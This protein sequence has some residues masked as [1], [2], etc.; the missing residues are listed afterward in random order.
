MTAQTPIHPVAWP[1]PSVPDLTDSVP[2]AAYH[3]DRLYDLLDAD[4][5]DRHALRRALD[6]YTHHLDRHICTAAADL[7]MGIC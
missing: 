1:A 5:L 6:D 7:A 3:L 2:N 4:P